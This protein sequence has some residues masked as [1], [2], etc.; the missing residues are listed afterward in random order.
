[1]TPLNGCRRWKTPDVRK[2]L[3]CRENAVT[4][5]KSSPLTRFLP[6]FALLAGLKVPAIADPQTTPSD[7][8]APAEP[9]PG[10]IADWELSPT[11]RA[12]DL[13]PERYLDGQP[14]AAIAWRSVRGEASGLVDIARYCKPVVEGTS[15]VWAR[16]VVHA[17]QKESRPFNFGYSDDVSL[18]LN[19]QILYR[20]ESG[21]RRRDPSFRGII[22]WNDTVYLPLET[23]DNELVLMV[24]DQFGGW[25]FMGRDLDAI[26]RH[27]A[28]SEAW[29]LP[30]RLSAPESVAYDS[31]R[32]A[33]YVSNFGGDC[34]S[35]IGLDGTVVAL[36]WVAGLKAPTGLKFFAGKLYAVERSGVAVIDPEQG[37]IIGRLSIMDAAFLNDLAIADDGVIYVT[38]SAKHCVFRI[39]SGKSE[40]WI[41][42]QAVQKP[43]GILVEKERLLVGVTEDG[44]IKSIDLKTKQVRTFLTL[45]P[46]ANM[47][48]LV[49]DGRD[50][51]L[52][53]DYYGRV[54][55]ADAAGRKTLLLDRRGPHHYTADFEYIPEE[56]LLIV[57]SLYDNRLTAY[58]LATP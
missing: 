28:L 29:D 42:G 37:M 24:T 4:V 13:A 21:G 15:K 39:S 46:G 56:G 8:P 48:G 32:K 16:A 34:L 36:K 54:Y 49:T 22:G 18:Y 31:G 2:D 19:G 25:G 12:F 51:Y 40:V 33:L 30:G 53:S 35:K 1:M 47:D 3:N 44:T 17:R 38:D 26:Y 55:R 14:S 10:I 27:P 52:F 50:G 45:G 7:P 9:I 20:G 5:L 57:P 11:V 58:R 6:L 41:E 43:N 23:G